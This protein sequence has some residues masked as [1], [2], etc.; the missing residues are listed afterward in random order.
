[1]SRKGGMSTVFPEGKRYLITV[2]FYKDDYKKLTK[3]AE[4]ETI[5]RGTLV[6]KLVLEGLR[7]L[8]AVIKL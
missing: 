6:R 5:A 3:L 1:M 8:E 4:R 2:W 7:R